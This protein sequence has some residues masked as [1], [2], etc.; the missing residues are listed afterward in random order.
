MLE[1]RK[2]KKNLRRRRVTPIRRTVVSTNLEN[3][4]LSD[5]EPPTRQH[6]PADMRLGTHIQQ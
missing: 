3:Q 1:L 4:D 6:I 5:T 2:R